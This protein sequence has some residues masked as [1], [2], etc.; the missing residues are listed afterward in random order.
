MAIVIWPAKT[1][2]T[3]RLGFAERVLS[4]LRLQRLARFG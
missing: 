1:T 3:F 2:R 4:G